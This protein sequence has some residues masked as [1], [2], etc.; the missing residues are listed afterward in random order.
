MNE[1]FNLNL[2]KNKKNVK[3][4]SFAEHFVDNLT[5]FIGK[6]YSI[7]ITLKH[8]KVKSL[9]DFYL[10]RDARFI[11]EKF[12]LKLYKYKKNEFFEIAKRIIFISIKKK[13]PHSF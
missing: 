2:Y 12:N 4:N 1:Y 7:F 10:K 8:L 6:K 9:K 13:I 11:K 5:N 3:T